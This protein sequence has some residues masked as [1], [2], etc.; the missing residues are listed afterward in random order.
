MMFLKHYCVCWVVCPAVRGM[1]GDLRQ[2]HIGR[3]YG[4]W[5]IPLTDRTHSMTRYCH[6]P[7]NVYNSRG[8][9]GYVCCNCDSR[10]VI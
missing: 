5:S 8:T 2:L 6:V 10:A 9:A 3:Q 4:R 1:S 7:L